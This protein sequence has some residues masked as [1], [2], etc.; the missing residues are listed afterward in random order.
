VYTLTQVLGLPDLLPP[1]LRNHQQCQG[2]MDGM[3][4]SARAVHQ[5]TAAGVH[6]HAGAW[7]P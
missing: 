2:P 1:I 6:T 7:T 5:H 4:S 3:H